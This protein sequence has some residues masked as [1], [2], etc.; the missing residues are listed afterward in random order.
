MQ[1]RGVE[2]PRLDSDLLLA[3]AL[4]VERLQLFLD[5]DRPVAGEELARFRQ[6]VQRRARREPVAYILGR[7]SFWRQEFFITSDVLVPR[8]ETELLV[9]TVLDVFP[10]DSQ[11]D[12]FFILELGVGSGAVLCA[13][14]LE[15]PAARGI[16][17]DISAAALGVAEENARRLGCLDRITLLR[18]D[19]VQPLC[20]PLYAAYRFQVVVANPPYV[21][22]GEL[23]HLEPEVSRWEPRQALEGG[24]DGLAVLRRIP[25]EVKPF[26]AAG[27]LLAVEIGETQ[28]DVVAGFLTEVGLQEV[29][30]RLDY[31]RRPRVVTGLG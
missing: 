29:A 14:L 27:G 24:V 31:G 11:Q 6:H 18:G 1:Q 23:V 9:E 2:T 12:P 10:P 25:G 19:L 16:G 13:L 15:Y 20:I 21:T 30:L 4:G 3:D 5:P 28:G 17:V 22:T 26:L 8:P 7:R